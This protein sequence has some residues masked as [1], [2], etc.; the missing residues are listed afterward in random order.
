MHRLWQ[1]TNNSCRVSLHSCHHH[2]VS[3]FSASCIY[4]LSQ[5]SFVLV[6]HKRVLFGHKR[7]RYCFNPADFRHSRAHRAFYTGAQ[8]HWQHGTS[9]ARALKTHLGNA[10]FGIKRH[11]LDISAIQHQIGSDAFQRFQDMLFNLGHR[12]LLVSIKSEY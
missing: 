2:A 11:K 3:P 9:N 5:T 7:L 6:A 8:R 1:F 12:I 10:S 4:S